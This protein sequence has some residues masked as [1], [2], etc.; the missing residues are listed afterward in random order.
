[1]PRGFAADWYRTHYHKKYKHL[2]I[3]AV[4]IGRQQSQQLLIV[5]IYYNYLT[6]R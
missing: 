5:M 2:S 3:P 4:E 6:K 1:M